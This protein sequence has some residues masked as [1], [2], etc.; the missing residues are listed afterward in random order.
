MRKTSFK[1]KKMKCIGKIM[2]RKH[3]SEPFDDVHTCVETGLCTLKRAELQ[4]SNKLN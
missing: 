4:F 2:D 3:E 1:R